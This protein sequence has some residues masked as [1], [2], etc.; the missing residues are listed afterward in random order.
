M[1]GK[2]WDFRDKHLQRR[3]LMRTVIT[4]AIGFWLGRQ[5]YIK[6][7]KQTA[8]KKEEKIK[9]R[10]KSFLEDNGLIENQRS[11]SS[12]SKKP[13]REHI[14]VDGSGK[15]VRK[16]VKYTDGSWKQLLCVTRPAASL[17]IL[18]ERFKAT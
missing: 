17:L 2:H 9:N 12:K 5:N 8:L 11:A 15:N 16:S 13:L 7:D 3:R 10:L 14:Y 18:C 1:V 6:Y 4:L